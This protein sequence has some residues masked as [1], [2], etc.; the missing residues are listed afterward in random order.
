MI[1]WLVF[2]RYDTESEVALRLTEDTACLVSTGK[3]RGK[4]GDL[5]AVFLKVLGEILCVKGTYEEVKEKIE[6][7]LN[8]EGDKNGKR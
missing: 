6:D 3:V 5:D 4:I 2:E 7:H 1:N 8:N